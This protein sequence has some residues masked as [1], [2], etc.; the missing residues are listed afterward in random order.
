MENSFAATPPLEALRMLLHILAAN[1]K[2]IA[3]TADVS[4]AFFEAKATREAAVEIPEEGRND[5]DGDVS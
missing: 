1:P 4:R 3:L 5:D 2:Q